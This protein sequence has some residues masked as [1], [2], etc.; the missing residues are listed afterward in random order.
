MVK[1]DG[2]FF[3]VVFG[4]ESH[5]TSLFRLNR[6]RDVADPFFKACDPAH[7]D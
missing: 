4:L 6:D 5:R 2:N 1:R 3:E 7:Q